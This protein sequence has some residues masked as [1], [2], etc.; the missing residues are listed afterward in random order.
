[1]EIVGIISA[2]CL[3]FAYQLFLENHSR[4]TNIAAAV[5]TLPAAA[6][7]WYEL[8]SVALRAGRL[9]RGACSH[10]SLIYGLAQP[11]REAA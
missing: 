1:M 2:G 6:I 3:I 11:W 7:I 10:D 4:W 8:V 9:D 5:L